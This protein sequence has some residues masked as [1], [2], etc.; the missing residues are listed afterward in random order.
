MTEKT[1]L[2]DSNVLM[3]FFKRHEASIALLDTLRKNGTFAIS[4]LTI[5]ELQA[6]WT[7]AQAAALFPALFDVVSVAELSREVLQY[8]GRLRR[9]YKEQG[10]VLS[11]IDTM[12][13]ATAI[14]HEMCMVTYNLRHFAPIKELKLWNDTSR[15]N[16]A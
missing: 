13:A 6:G 11:A 5:M 8:A 10:V 12:I 16:T 15:E 1:Y 9:D 3:S 4:A 14:K 2:I 7:D